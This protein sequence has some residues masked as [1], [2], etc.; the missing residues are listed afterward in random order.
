MEKN[1]IFISSKT[2]I[3][4]QG[5]LYMY[6]YMKY[7]WRFMDRRKCGGRRICSLINIVEKHLF[8]ASDKTKLNIGAFTIFGITQYRST[9]APQCKG[10]F[11]AH[12]LTFWIPL[13]TYARKSLSYGTYGA[14]I[15]SGRYE[16]KCD[17]VTLDVLPQI[18][19]TRLMYPKD[20]LFLELK[21][22]VFKKCLDIHCIVLNIQP[23]FT[24]FQHFTWRQFLSLR[25]TIYLFSA[26]NKLQ[27]S[28]IIEKWEIVSLLSL[29]LH[30]FR[31]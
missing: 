26:S 4:Y 2:S 22:E 20:Y 24:Q 21:I 14:L 13:I 25:F 23:Q 11:W 29:H 15:L 6:P 9:H 10:L 16:Q 1:L 7:V 3:Y 30:R 28:Y 19:L 31:K 27:I 8:A 18:V 5:L 12:S 17:I